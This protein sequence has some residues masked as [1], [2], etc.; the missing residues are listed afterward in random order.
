M[1]KIIFL[2]NGAK[3]PRG[4]EFLTVSLITNLRKD[5]FHP[6]LVYAEEG[7]IVKEIINAG[8]DAT[9]IP[10]SNKITTIYPR[11]IK[12]HNPVFVVTFIWRLLMGGGIISI[13][14]LI[15]LIKQND[16]RLIYCADNLSKLIGGIAGK[17]AKIRVVAHCHDDFQKDTLGKTM[18]LFYMLLLDRIVTV[19][20][21]VNRFFLKNQKGRCKA[22]TVY[23]GINTN[24][25]DP[26]NVGSNMKVE[27][28]LKD[29]SFIIGSIG[30]LEKD[31][32]QE[33]LLEAIAK[34]KSEGVDNIACV[35]CGIGPEEA[36]LR[37]LVNT[38]SLENEV[39]FLGYR[40]DIPE[41]L[42]MLDIVAITSLTIESFSMVAVE[43][44]AMNVPVI[45]TKVGGLP[46]VV[47]DARTGILVPPGNAGELYK[48]LKYLMEQ[49]TVRKEMGLNGRK[50]VL[51]NFTI[52]QNVR[53][54]EEVFLN[55][56]SH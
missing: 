23:N 50:R 7:S 45:A 14:K 55:L 41:M 15:T 13:I 20:E 9:Q 56:L 33:Y 38:R 35:I 49:P 2:M 3:P 8:V 24:V 5:T 44:M 28:R 16:I 27:L 52:E 42:K 36:N 17:M 32:G 54:T 29:D 53:K 21:K 43:A 10:L 4:G 47:E 48:A 1:I 18:R 22:V 39:L 51:Q 34:L 19:S 11:V 31:K 46:E 12:I 37:E 40:N 6:I 26:E 25:F 30:V